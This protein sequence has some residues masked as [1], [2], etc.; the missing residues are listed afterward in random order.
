MFNA[1][2]FRIALF[3]LLT[4]FLWEMWQMPF[5]DAGG[6]TM[7]ARVQGCSL[8]SIGDA[9]IMVFAYAMASWKAGRRL[10]LNDITPGTLLV[11]LGTGLAVTIAIEHIAL[12]FAFGWRYSELMPLGPIIGT[13]LVPVA[14]WIVVPL[15]TLWLARLP[16]LRD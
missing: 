1:P 5:Y 7:A 4:A 12:N 11:Y 16:S 13:G 14:M 15:A 3:G 9:G 2:E 6:A 10:W 8:A